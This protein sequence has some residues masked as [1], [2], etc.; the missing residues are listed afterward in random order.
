MT[1]APSSL[2]Q[3]LAAVVSIAFAAPG[4]AA[5]ERPNIV[6]ILADDLGIH[7]LGAYDRSD[8]ATPHLD[9]LAG[10]GARFTAAYCAQP[11]CSPSRAALMT[12]KTPARL[13]LTT[14]LP[15]RPDAP[16]QILLHPRM[17]MELPLE[18]T[19]IAERLKA[20]GYATA[21]AGKWHLG[22]KGFLPADQGFD[23][24]VPGRANTAPSETEGGKGEY[25]LAAAAEAFIDE[26]R[27]RP[28]F[29]YLP[30]DN[31]H[32]P[33]AA[34]PALI[35]KHRGA[36]NPV[37]AAML[38]TLDDSVGR[39]VARLE[40]RG[41]TE[42]TIVVFTS[43]NGGLHVLEGKETPATHNGRFRAG[44]GFCY[45]GGLRVPL[46][47]RWPG[48]IPAGVVVDAPVMNT[49][50]TPTL[51]ELAG[52]PPSDGLDGA[53][54][55]SL[56]TKGE[57]PPPRPL[58]WHFPHYTNQGGRPAGAVR[59]GAWKLIE[60][61]E[62]GR[63]ELFDLESD[64]GEAVDL[65]A[66]EP[67]RVAALRGKLEAWRRAVG[68]QQN[69][70]NPSFDG[71]LWK[72]IY[73]ELDVS[74]L[75]RG[76]S[77]G[78]MAPALEPW[79]RRMDH[80]VQRRAGKPAA[81]P[82]A[83]AVILEARD[84]KVHGSKLRYEPE[85]HKDTLG[86]WTD[87]GDWAEWAFDAPAA[88]DFEVQALVGCGAASGGAEVEIAVAGQTLSFKVEETG[89]FQRFVPVTL[90]RIR[91]E[92]AG[93]QALSVRARSKPGPAVMDL[94]RVVLRAAGR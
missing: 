45:E 67:A 27:E 24:Y 87:A 36:F 39:V 69:A 46:I 9:R 56:L 18:E 7:D 13:H 61:Y 15:G 23:R 31:P 40:A 44:K 22:G 90:G 63:L 76:Q 19:T 62:D 54:F 35:E 88:G 83:G 1:A 57:A 66:R 29:L 26:H 43:D 3:L 32:V 42:R 2:A 68:A 20:A 53:S 37:Y 25:E 11:I 92:K 58:F 41:L 65:A 77:A 74:R 50:W 64:P 59:D 52:L 75:D 82:G 30:H 48:R 85:P 71:G 91:F 70:A 89:H 84:A 73:A 80:A 5:A 79:R 38:E 8:H 33:L 47:V 51:L 16:S 4:P 28:F 10:E 6:F 49:D 14:Y 17:R 72:G 12:G 60:H 55:A 21:C 94:R 34:K 93:P 86:Y 81:P 78:A